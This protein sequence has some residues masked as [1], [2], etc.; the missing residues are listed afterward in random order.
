MAEAV[1]EREGR[2][3]PAPPAETA[4]GA[5]PRP[6][7][8]TRRIISF[9][10]IGLALLVGGVLALADF[11]S[12][13][14]ELRTRSLE[15]EARIIAAALADTATLEDGLGVDVDRSWPVLAR[16][17]EPA[18]VRARIFDRGARLMA[19][20]RL[21]GTAPYGLADE[22]PRERFDPASAVLDWAEAGGRL[23]RAWLLGER[24]ETVSD[25]PLGQVATLREVYAA[26]G[27]RAARGRRLNARGELIVSVAVPIKRESKV[28]GALVLSTQGGDI[29]A[30]V[31]S[32]R[33]SIL[34]VFLVALAVSV[35]L[36]LLL[37][38]AISRPIERLARAALRAEREG[39][40]LRGGQRATL[41]DMTARGDEI[42]YLSGALRRMTDTFYARIEATERF[43]ADATHEIKNPLTSLRSAVETLRYTRNEADRERLLRVMEHDVDRL[44][45]LVTDISNA[46]R[47]DAELVR[48]ARAEFDLSRTLLGITEH[49]REVAGKRNVRLRD[50][51]VE[52]G[53]RVRGTE[54][55]LA[56]VFVNLLHNALSFSPQGGE[57][58]L[59]A[60]RGADGRVR[61]TV[62]DEGPG[63]PED[64]LEAIFERLYS[65]RP[66]PEAFGNHSG[67]GLSISRQIVEAH[68][69]TIRAEN[70]RPACTP[71][72]GARFVVEL[73][74]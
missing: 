6:S 65:Q 29:D 49:M 12:Q 64:A 67:L 16:L 20:T 27:E 10:L 8:L 52:A 54:A 72:R 41:P 50:E 25:A 11:R 45:R 71:R 42:G 22:E 51:A 3:R 36:S 38:R 44:N 69:G 48:E 4:Y 60:A 9:N 73:P 32:E 66:D 15:T 55:R 7:R 26:L 53:L 62:E 37:S 56:Q 19:D 40:A 46:S 14:I 63:I 21:R 74:G 43:A 61:V 1:E 23:L 28:H 17:V 59:A 30:I 34:Q 24:F 58:R 33:V 31:R 68:G 57:I 35:V 18:R 13:L 2:A 39:H 5:P 47:L 70:I